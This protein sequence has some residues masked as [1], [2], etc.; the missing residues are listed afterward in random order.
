M[1]PRPQRAARARRGGAVPRVD[2]LVTIGQLERVDGR[3]L[4]ALT[5][6][7]C[8]DVLLNKGE[9]IGSKSMHAEVFTVPEH[10]NVVVKIVP[11][12]SHSLNESEKLIEFSGRTIRERLHHYPVLY[13]THTCTRAHSEFN[14]P[15][16][17]RAAFDDL[18]SVNVQACS[19]YMQRNL[20][21]AAAIPPIL[22]KFPADP[23]VDQTARRW[24]VFKTL[25]LPEDR[26]YSEVKTIAIFAERADSD[27][28]VLLENAER[29]PAELASILYQVAVALSYMS[30]PEVGGYA[31]G[32]LHSGNVLVREF[33]EPKKLTYS[34]TQGHCAQIGP[35]RDYAIIWDAETIGP[36]SAADHLTVL[37]DFKRLATSLNGNQRIRARQPL[38]T[39]RLLALLDR[40]E[41]T[42]LAQIIAY[43]SRPSLKINCAPRT[44]KP[45]SRPQSPEASSALA[46]FAS[47][48]LAPASSR[49]SPSAPSQ[50]QR[51]R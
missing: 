1:S 12:T 46:P 27:L 15:E 38:E 6:L 17:L 11:Y 37:E 19:N 5:N 13:A 39:R 9:R 40:R 36:A 10:P 50:L 2:S 45:I 49:R 34:P 41:W 21:G 48:T 3:A 43:L 23:T 28:G 7:S 31:H 24:R 47:L 42:S 22:R 33:A 51:G 32:D 26:D 44:R 20:R 16:L 4:A 30:L 35:V 18:V 25:G 14:D 8:S 29:T